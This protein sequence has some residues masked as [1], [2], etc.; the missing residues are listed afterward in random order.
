MSALEAARE[1]TTGLDAHVPFGGTGRT[2]TGP[3]EQG[4]DAMDCYC[5]ERTV[6]WR[7]TGA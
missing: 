7:E 3:R 2:A 5:H 4:P 6:H 1:A